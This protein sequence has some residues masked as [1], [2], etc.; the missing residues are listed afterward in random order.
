MFGHLSVFPFLVGILR[1]QKD[2]RERK[3]C[4]LQRRNS[5]SHFVGDCE[6]PWVLIRNFLFSCLTLWSTNSFLL[7][8]AVDLHDNIENW[9][10]LEIVEQLDDLPIQHGDFPSFLPYQL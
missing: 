9:W 8:I 1:H 5:S 10:K 2:L 7:K 4:L 3:T 6:N